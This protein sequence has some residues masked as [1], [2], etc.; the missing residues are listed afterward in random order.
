MRF[1]ECRHRPVLDTSTAENVGRVEG[2]AVDAAAQRVHA[3]RVGKHK[4]G[5]VLRWGDVQGF[6]PDAVTVQTAQ[7]VREPGDDPLDRAGDVIGV[8]ILTDQGFELGALEDVDFDPATG[9]LQQLHVA[10][11]AIDAATLLGAGHYA[12]V[13]RHPSGSAAG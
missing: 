3:V 1:S 7:S 5:S 13:V 6:G 11:R 12:V 8:R 9:Q 10:D 4:G 2:F